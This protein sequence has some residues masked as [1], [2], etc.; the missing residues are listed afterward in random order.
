MSPHGRGDEGWAIG[1]T[2]CD[3]ER[4]E[5]VQDAMDC[6]LHRGLIEHIRSPS[7]VGDGTDVRVIRT[8]AKGPL[9][10]CGVQ[11]D[12]DSERT[13]EHVGLRMGEVG[14]QLG[15]VGA[16]FGCR[17]HVDDVVTWST[18]LLP[19]TMCDPP[20]RVPIDVPW[21]ATIQ[22]TPIWEV[23]TPHTIAGEV[24][25]WDDDDH[26]CDVLRME[27]S[28]RSVKLVERRFVPVEIPVNSSPWIPPMIV[29]VGPGGIRERSRSGSAMSHPCSGRAMAS[30]SSAWNL[31]G[32]V[33]G[34]LDGCPILL[35]DPTRGAPDPLPTPRPCGWRGVDPSTSHER[36]LAHLGDHP[37]WFR[38]RMEVD[39]F[40][41]TFIDGGPRVSSME[42]G[43]QRQYAPNSICFGCGPANSKGLRI[44]SK[45]SEGGLSLTFMPEAHHEAFRE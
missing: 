26:P 18:D 10:W 30:R 7:L 24:D 38:E 6:D 20:S 27:R 14:P 19:Y 21:E 40:F 15:H 28:T 1:I 31:G 43:V 29:T 12:L 22:V 4:S 8:S 32:W 13:G 33:G 36:P 35:I 23:P 2:G 45:R 16:T 17:M 42:I 3:L 25:D 37:P 41:R 44:D 39:G 5:H 9:R 11:D 34:R